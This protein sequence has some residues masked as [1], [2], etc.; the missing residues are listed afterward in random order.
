MDAT[1]MGLG[2]AFDDWRFKDL[3]ESDVTQHIDILKS[4]WTELSERMAEK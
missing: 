4:L 2:K 1:I 3:P